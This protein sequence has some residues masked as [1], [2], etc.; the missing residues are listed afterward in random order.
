MN[1]NWQMFGR[2]LQ[3]WPQGLGRRGSV[4]SSPGHRFGDSVIGCQSRS[5]LSLSR[6]TP[7]QETR[8]TPM[9]S[10]PAR[11]GDASKVVAMV[12]TP[13]AATT[14][15]AMARKRPLPLFGNVDSDADPHGSDTRSGII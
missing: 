4:S 3:Y 2:Q 11:D 10:A 15:A 12:K 9:G 5:I 7:S 13:A 14:A 6:R 8:I 1:S